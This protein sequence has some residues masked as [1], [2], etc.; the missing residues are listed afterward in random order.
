MFPSEEAI[1]DAIKIRYEPLFEDE[2]LRVAYKLNE[3]SA[4]LPLADLESK[5]IRQLTY[6]NIYSITKD[7]Q[8][9]GLV[10][11]DFELI[12]LGLALKFNDPWLCALLKSY[13]SG[14]FPCA[15]SPVVTTM[16][17]LLGR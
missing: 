14:K 2:W 4:G 16:A 3:L 17:K 13:L 12:G 1:Y 11:D 8:V 15:I 7:P 6:E 5:P 10:T 9:C